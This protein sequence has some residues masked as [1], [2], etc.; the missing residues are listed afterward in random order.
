MDVSKIV[1]VLLT[2]TRTYQVETANTGMPAALSGA[3]KLAKTPVMAGRY[4][5]SVASS[6]ASF[7]TET[8]RNPSDQRS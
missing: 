8:N 3:V 4:R 6:I 2:A 5:L 1:S 7:Q